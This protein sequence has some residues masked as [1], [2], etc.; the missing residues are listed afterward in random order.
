MDRPTSQLAIQN[1]HLLIVAA[2]DPSG[3]A[4]V[5]LDRA[6]AEAQGAR[7]CAVVSALTVQNNSGLQRTKKVSPDLVIEQIGALEEDLGPF[8]AAKFGALGSPALARK[9]ARW[10]QNRP[11]LKLVL[12]PVSRP[13]RGKASLI[14][15]S[16][17]THRSA[18]RELLPHT[19]LLTPNLPEARWLLGLPEDSEVP[20][21]ELGERLL[22]KGPK[23]VLIKGGHAGGSR[24]LDLL[25]EHS[26][27]KK[28]F[29][30]PRKSGEFHGTGCYLASAIAA[31]L[32]LGRKLPGAVERANES[33]AR[34]MKAAQAV[35]AAEVRQLRPT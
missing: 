30:H 1:R 16:P 19:Y 2:L 12:D 11:N 18:L 22:E 27:R 3:G 32:E 9:L 26:G 23:A 33:L 34:A 21:Y 29:V 35:G 25:I 13:S 17:R 7:S 6:V 28:E 8:E 15:A 31:Q 20:F 5:L 4:G 24:V 14:E 10:A